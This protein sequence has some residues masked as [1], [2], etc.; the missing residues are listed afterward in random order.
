MEVESPP[1]ATLEAWHDRN[2]QSENGATD[3]SPDKMD[4]V[5]AHL[6]R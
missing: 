5:M 2:N 1:E 3:A 4:P 6:A